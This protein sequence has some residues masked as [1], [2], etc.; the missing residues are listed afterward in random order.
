[1]I[2]KIHYGLWYGAL[3]GIIPFMFNYAVEYASA[4]GT[5]H[6]ILFTALPFVALLAKPIFCSVADRY[7]AHHHLLL[8]FILMTLIGYGSLALYPFIPGFVANHK[9]I[10]WILYCLSAFIGNTSMCVVNSIG[11][12][13]AINS[14]ERKNQSYGEYRL[15]GPVGFGIFGAIWGMAN[16]IPSLP[17]FTPGI[18]TMAILLMLNII[19]LA[20]WYDK[21]EF[22]MLKRRNSNSP[23][24]INTS[25]YNSINAENGPCRTEECGDNISARIIKSKYTYFFKLCTR[26]SSIFVYFFLFT[27]CGIMTAIHWQFFFR[28]LEQLLAKQKNKDFSLVATLALP[29]QSLGGELVF[30]FLSGRIMEALG[31]SLT[32][33]I[34]LFSFSARYLAYAFIVPYVTIYWIL[35]IELLQGPAF[36]LMYCVLTYQAKYYADCVDKIVEESVLS[37]HNEQT[38]QN[39]LHATLQ[40][41]LGAAFEGLGLGLGA[42]IGGLA[43]D[44][45]PLLMWT[46]GGCSSFLVASI[47]LIVTVTR[48]SITGL[49]E[50]C[51]QQQQLR[52]PQQQQS[53][54]QPQQAQPQSQQMDQQLPQPQQHLLDDAGPGL[55]TTQTEV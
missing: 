30:F 53:Q 51:R 52:Q 26:H 29:V 40:G 42:I 41:V 34:C 55:S 32:L 49:T 13:L 46:I 2:F 27:F 20:F 47:Y 12:S 4:T 11:D 28:F 48:W 10:V 36:G 21:D 22:K 33:T 1:M 45:D 39:S 6:G 17:K 19:V 3:V 16:E 23:A 5:Q 31:P 14:C 44:F 9:N 18:I 7:A 37:S 50:Y 54:P 35:F 25:T 15:W 38:L 24:Q 8:F 43:F